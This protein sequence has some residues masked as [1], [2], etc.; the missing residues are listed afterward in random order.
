MPD[1]E[2]QS[3][4]HVAPWYDTLMAGVPYEQWVRYL[5]ELL[6][7]FGHRAETVLDLACGTGK[8]SRLLAMKGYEVVGV[9]GSEA[10]I[11]EARRRTPSG[12]VEYHCQRMELL[13]L[14][15]RF[16]LVVSLFDSLNYLTE[17]DDLRECFRRV[18]GHLNPGGLLVFD[19]N[20]IYA[21]EAD[22][23]NQ[24]SFGPRRRI[25]YSWR[26]AYDRETRLCHV[27][28][29][30]YVKERGRRREFQEVHVQRAYTVE[31]INAMLRDAGLEILAVYDGYTLEPARAKSD[32]IF[33]VAQRPPDGTG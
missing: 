4:T 18:A 15:R 9:D 22:L 12:E 27:Y 3:F 21:F 11:E 29:T 16:D 13:S 20:G 10:M 32:R 1:S 17:P 7:H 30:F 26:S 5:E 25:E 31:E 19:L 14:G 8:V 28:M 23:F 33:W 2:T 24:E 6:R